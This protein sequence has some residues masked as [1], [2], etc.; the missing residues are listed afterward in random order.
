MDPS[1]VAP[2][3]DATTPVAAPPP[4][5][6]TPASASPTPAPAATPAGA[7]PFLRVN[8]TTSYANADEAIKGYQSAQDR[9]AQLRGW[10]ELTK[11]YEGFTSPQELAG[12][13]DAYIK[14]LAAQA[15]AAQPVANELT[16][17]WKQTDEYLN[18]KL[19]YVKKSEIEELRSKLAA[20]ES[21]HQGEQAARNE[22]AVQDGRNS[23]VNLA[24][25]SGLIPAQGDITAEDQAVLSRIETDIG[26]RIYEQSHNPQ[27]Q[28]IPGS[29]EDRFYRG[30]S[31]ARRQIINE[32]FG[33]WLKFGET[34][35]SRRQAK[36]AN[37]R[38]AAL[39]GNPRPLPPST[40][41]SAPSTPP[42]PLKSFRDPEFMRRVQ[43]RV[44]AAT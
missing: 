23:L 38:S 7:Q 30:D 9:I 12:H 3:P 37:E 14:M 41:P 28:L 5:A 34:F 17:E 39:S 6:T 29:A 19:G 25:E 24:R 4:A 18:T 22:A 44:D 43:A 27:G 1:V 33:F 31:N 32:Q 20:L 10:E 40:S 35:A 2:A 21:G 13:L 11:Q 42:E 15:P 26:N 36:Q 16:P 8:D